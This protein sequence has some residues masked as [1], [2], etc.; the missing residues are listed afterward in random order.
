MS[1]LSTPIELYGLGAI[2]TL[3][4]IGRGGVDGTDP[5]IK[6]EEEIAAGVPSAKTTAIFSDIAIVDSTELASTQ[7]GEAVATG[8]VG[9]R[10]VVVTE[11]RLAGR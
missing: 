4:N 9:K 10:S 3:L 6:A 1:R 7:T 8:T 5:F 11:Q 2:V